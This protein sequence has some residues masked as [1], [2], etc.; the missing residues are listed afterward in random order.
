MRRGSA[1]VRVVV[2]L[3]L[4]LAA[5]AAAVPAAE[6]AP[7]TNERRRVA[8]E[9]AATVC[10]T[11]PAIPKLPVTVEA[12]D[13]CQRVVVENVDPDGDNL[14]VLAACQAFLPPP[15]R[16]AA[17]FCAAAIDT[18]LDPARTLFL[19][20]VVPA[21]EALPCVTTTPA[22]FDCLTKQ[23]HIW[24][25]SSIIS[26]WQGLLTVLTSDTEVIGMIDGWRNA[27]IVSLYSDVGSVGATVLLGVL[28]TSLVVS[29]IR[30]DFRQFGHTFLGVVVWGV[31]WSGGVTIAV[32]LLKASDEV[33][34]WLAGR[35][36][37]SGTTDLD[38]AGKHFANW[39]DYISGA[40]ATLPVHPTWDPGSSTALLI[41][42][43]L[44][45]AIVATL[46][47]L[48][49]RNI[50]LLMIIMA[51]PLTL[52][53][54]AGP[55]LTREWFTAAVR[56]FV[57]LLLA[58]P[59]IVIA[60]RLGAVMVTVPERGEPQATFSSAMLGIAIILLAAL[61]PGVIYRFSGGLMNTQAG[62]APR[63]TGG[64]SSQSAQSVQS[65]MD[66]T[67]LIMERNAPRPAL[68]GGPAVASARPTSTSG[69]AGLA[70]PLGLAA[71]AATLAGGAMESGGRWLAGHAATAGGVTGDV[72]AP[73]VPTPPISR[74]PYGPRGNRTQGQSAPKVTDSRAAPRTEKAHIT[75]LPQPSPQIA[76]P[77]LANAAHMIIPGSVVP[78][79]PK[80]LP[81]PP[82]ALP[83]R[84]ND[85]E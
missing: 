15:A 58:K 72:E 5:F 66:M 32:L 26:L 27:G 54:T 37:G 22:A 68:A 63:A 2:A 61:L 30:F 19:D 1:L 80:E 74:G 35:P 82:P 18:V 44:I 8:E 59:L 77:A 13:L 84:K 3:L 25:E 62:N 75:I 28:L 47:A 16:A 4:T 45:I 56:M 24:L 51:L 36:D 55:R 20:K 69:G 64:F 23:V 70:R 34:R 81:S 83:G 21:A 41:C 40:S 79:Q 52:A 12:K 53:G 42:L 46:V 43:L 57:A 10:R 11:I 14:G 71:V 85:H 39:V 7:T 9:V 31:F 60:V 67:R 65:S 38:R 33:A 76:R 6:A 17:R 78:D 29:A 49:M 50:A 48:L 73:H